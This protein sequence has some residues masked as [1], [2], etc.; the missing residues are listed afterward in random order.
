MRE[1]ESAEEFEKLTNGQT[2]DI[3]VDMD[4]KTGELKVREEATGNS[5]EKIQKLLKSD[6]LFQ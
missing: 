1:I 6:I 5:E 4:E 2:P 3:A